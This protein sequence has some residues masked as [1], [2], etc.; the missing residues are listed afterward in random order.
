MHLHELGKHMCKRTPIQGRFGPRKF[1]VT[2]DITLYLIMIYFS[3]LA[4]R[5]KFHKDNHLNTTI[6]CYSDGDLSCDNFFSVKLFLLQ[7]ISEYL[8]GKQKKVPV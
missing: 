2:H 5:V 6:V 4:K 8:R 1:N 3:F 7:L